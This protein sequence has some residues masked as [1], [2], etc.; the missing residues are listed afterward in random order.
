MWA[1]IAMTTLIFLIG[2]WVVFVHD[3][4]DTSD[5][6]ISFLYYPASFSMIA[7]MALILVILARTGW[8]QIKADRR[9]LSLLVILSVGIAGCTEPQAGPSGNSRT[10]FRRVVLDGCEYWYAD[11]H[12][13]IHPPVLVH[14]ANC[15]NPFH[16]NNGK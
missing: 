10:E 2:L 13:G 9:V 1:S 14:K 16:R 4:K 15:T 5:T 6:V 11:G 12:T 8:A 7:V 3:P